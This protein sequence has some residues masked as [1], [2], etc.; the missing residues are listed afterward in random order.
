MAAE[1]RAR[2]FK[3][4]ISYSHA[5]DDKLAPAI[6][7]A[8]HR[9]AK[10]WYRMRAMRVFRDKT[11]LAANP[12]LWDTLEKALQNS[13]Y[14]LLM[15]SPRSAQSPWV[16][17]EIEWWLAHRTAESM[18]ILLTD[19]DLAWDETLRSYD[20]NRTT[21]LPRVMDTR[22]DT[23]PLYVDFR[24]ARTRAVLSLRQTEFRA[25]ILDL[26]APLLGKDKDE[27]DGEDV[28]QHRVTRTVSWLAATIVLIFALT[29]AW[30]AYV[31]TQQR[32][33]AE[34]R[35]RRARQLLYVAEMTLAQKSFE[36]HNVPRAKALLEMFLPGAAGS[37]A[38]DLRG[39]DWYYL[40]LMCHQE[41]GTLAGNNAA[42]TS[43]AFSNDGA[44][45]ATAA[46]TTGL[47]Q[48]GPSEVK[49]WDAKTW[50]AIVE[51]NGYARV[52]LTGDGT[53][54]AVASWDGP[55]KL[56][57][58]VVR[59]EL[60]TLDRY[61]TSVQS[62]AFAPDGRLLATGEL[63]V[64]RLWD[65]A[66]R[67]VLHVWNAF[68]GYYV[69][70]VVFSPDGQVVAARSPGDTVKL[71]AVSSR[72]EIAAVDK[73]GLESMAFSPDNVVVALGGRDG[74]ITLWDL[75][76]RKELGTMRG[77]TDVVR[78]VAFSR[79]GRL[80]ASGSNDRTVRLWDVRSRGALT[81]WKGHAG[82]V[83]AVAF[84]PDGQVVATGGVDKTI[85]FWNVAAVSEF[86]LADNLRQVN[87]VAFSPDGS[88]LAT[89][90][91][92]P[93]ASVSLWDVKQRTKLVTLKDDKDG[94]YIAESLAFS[95]DG[96]ILASKAENVDDLKLWDLATKRRLPPWNGFVAAAAA[97][98]FS[99]VGN[100]LAVADLTHEDN[101][102]PIPE[103]NVWNLTTR[104]EMATLR[105]PAAMH[106]SVLWM[107]WRSAGTPSRLS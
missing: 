107:P 86:A 7:S 75:K 58:T 48:G 17:R 33:L 70:D 79:D 20:W 97:F 28:R 100:L 78:E 56:W 105:F 53:T 46:G 90:D 19:G 92:R 57:D 38:D 102:T 64:V 3:A 5:A 31:A 104:K 62:M 77:H 41:L 84:A 11:S 93:G 44:L 99:P 94:D 18:L 101:G 45:I 52:A 55:V 68:D 69:P 36:E 85:K 89:A 65:V 15:A 63:G 73:S 43:I 34:E 60:A 22:F 91:R 2:K 21:A 26:A 40:W 47:L 71:Y 88:I 12:G 30:Q 66:Q 54:L 80:L 67:S 95:S 9:F 96:T 39:F 106:A 50:K 8:L 1:G 23:E 27:L 32:R 59:K 37:P 87:A 72:K 6:Q 98:S 49:V 83:A 25:S 61:E 82:A 103:I 4:F 81:V 35:E 42:V 10:P 74:S 16:Q 24:W 14:F 76:G 13:E 51:L 29:A